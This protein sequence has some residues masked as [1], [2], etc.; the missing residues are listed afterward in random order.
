MKINVILLHGKD[1]DPTK[2]WYPRLEIQMKKHNL[3]FVAPVLPNPE[4][5]YIEDWLL[6]I[7][8]VNP[9]ENTILIWH[10][11]G[12]VAVLRYLEKQNNNFRVKKVIL[13]ATNSWYIKNMRSDENSNWFYTDEGY[14]F[15]KIKTYCSDFV[16]LHSK[17]DKWVPYR[18]WE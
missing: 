2:K 16:V 3:D 4:N 14:D 11:R 1:T 18:A 17:D 5:P 15:E 13:I 10:S 7:D 8:K 9:N 12:W 6:E